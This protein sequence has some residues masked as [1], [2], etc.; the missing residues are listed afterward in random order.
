MRFFLCFFVD[1]C[2]ERGFVRTGYGGWWE[3]AMQVVVGLSHIKWFLVA[4]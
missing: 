2:N 4:N 1:E 3:M